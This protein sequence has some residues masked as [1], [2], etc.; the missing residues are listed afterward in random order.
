GS[1]IAGACGGLFYASHA[2][3]GVAWF[4][5]AMVVPGLAI[6]LGLYRLPPLPQNARTPPTPMRRG[7]MP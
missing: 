3:N 1:S 6:A 2:W 5:V 7:A 4:V